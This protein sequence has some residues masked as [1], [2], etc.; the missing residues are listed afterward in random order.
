MGPGV[1]ECE[2]ELEDIT[3]RKMAIGEE[4]SKRKEIRIDDD[5]NF[6]KNRR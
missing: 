5:L 2:R 6:L 1:T 3:D 4:K